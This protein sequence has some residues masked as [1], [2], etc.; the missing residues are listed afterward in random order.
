MKK[1]IIFILLF[2][3]PIVVFAQCARQYPPATWESV[4][5]E[6][7]RV[8]REFV[9]E[10]R[11]DPETLE[12]IYSITLSAATPTIIDVVVYPPLFDDLYS[13]VIVLMDTH[14]KFILE[15]GPVGSLPHQLRTTLLAEATQKFN[16]S[17]GTPKITRSDDTVVSTWICTNWY[18]SASVWQERDSEIVLFYFHPDDL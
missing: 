16:S 4:E 15:S 3:L 1:F 8:A 7:R 14:E 11:R 2:V 9:E 18:S 10:H 17:Y 5:N 12:K 6:M 13:I